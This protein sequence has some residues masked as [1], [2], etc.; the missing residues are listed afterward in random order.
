[1]AFFTV[2]ILPALTTNAHCGECP[3]G[4]NDPDAFEPVRNF[5]EK[6]ETDKRWAHPTISGGCLYIRHG[7]ILL[8]YEIR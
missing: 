8:A 7:D 4:Q 3:S 1:V 2:S 6:K 5:P